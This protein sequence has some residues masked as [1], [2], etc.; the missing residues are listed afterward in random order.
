MSVSQSNKTIFSL[1]T[2]Q[3]HLRSLR[4][5]PHY[6]VKYALSAAESHTPFLKSRLPYMLF[7]AFFVLYSLSPLRISSDR[8]LKGL[9]ENSES[10]CIRII[11]VEKFLDMLTD[12]LSLDGLDNSDD[13]DI[14]VMVK[15]KRALLRA[16][17]Q[18]FL[19]LIA[20]ASHIGARYYLRNEPLK[21]SS[22][23]GHSHY[24]EYFNILEVYHSPHSGLAPPYLLS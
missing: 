13:A 21:H 16:F 1:R 7:L 20:I 6:C 23:F 17:T 4:E 5:M 24:S 12:K 8:L 15:K 22:R 9:Q 2:I 18:L 19:L 11:L 14:E 10:S 3:G